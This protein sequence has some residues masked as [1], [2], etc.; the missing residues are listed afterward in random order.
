MKLQNGNAPLSD[1]HLKNAHWRRR[2]YAI[3]GSENSFQTT[4]KEYKGTKEQRSK[5]LFS[6]GNGK[7]IR[8]SFIIAS[9][10]RV[11][12]VTGAQRGRGLHKTVPRRTEQ[13]VHPKY[14]WPQR[15]EGRRKE[16]GRKE[17]E[18]RKDRRQRS[19]RPVVGISLGALS[20]SA[21]KAYEG[22]RLN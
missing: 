15:K 10:F 5:P 11:I 19:G 13:E 8:R 14:S 9:A 21:V 3:I 18:R 12:F 1:R 4:R 16:G 20:H 17:E 7:T 22:T 6:I 2:F